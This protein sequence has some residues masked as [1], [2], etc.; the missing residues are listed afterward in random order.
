MKTTYEIPKL[1]PDEIKAIRAWHKE[2]PETRQ[3]QFELLITERPKLIFQLNR[4]FAAEHRV[5]ASIAAKAAKAIA[6]AATKAEA[7]SE[8]VGKGALGKAATR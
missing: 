2:S 5:L 6:A 1:T 4:M 7:K 8:R 3:A